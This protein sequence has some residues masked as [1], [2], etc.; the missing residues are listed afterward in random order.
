MK[1]IVCALSTLFFSPISTFA[2]EYRKATFQD[3]DSMVVLM[4][5]EAH[6]DSDKIVIVPKAFRRNYVQDGIEKG[7]FFVA[8]ASSEKIVGYKKLFGITDEFEL[9][10]ILL[11]ELRFQQDKHVMS[12]LVAIDDLNKSVIDYEPIDIHN[13]FYIYNGADFTHPEYRN[14]GINNQLML[15]A[16]GEVGDEYLRMEHKRKLALVYGLT[17]DNAGDDNDIVGGRT[18]GIV[19][20]MISLVKVMAKK[21]GVPEPASLLLS[22]YTAYKPSFDP[23]SSECIPLPDAESIPGYGC[24][25]F[26]ALRDEKC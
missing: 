4:N 7:R 16:L 13:T 5:E 25:I 23:E 11:D 15:H 21:I 17:K 14:R 20:E 2:M 6:K 3:I 24:M 26:C 12:V 19:K 22:R 10:N 8:V 18:K 9:N 1:N